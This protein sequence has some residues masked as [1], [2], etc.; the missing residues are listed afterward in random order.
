MTK[1]K[2]STKPGGETLPH[3]VWEIAYGRPI[4]RM[5]S[6]DPVEV[7]LAWLASLEGGG[8]VR[9]PP[10]IIIDNMSVPIID[11]QNGVL[12][13]TS[14][15]LRQRDLQRQSNGLPPYWAALADRLEEGGKSLAD[16][17]K[18]GQGGWTDE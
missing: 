10:A 5:L 12:A 7:A 9:L 8:P 16:F 15:L 18:A 6:R 17:E 1:H 11:P 14:H 3:Y 2:P 4:F 13:L